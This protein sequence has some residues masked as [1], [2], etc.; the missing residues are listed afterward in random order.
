MPYLSLYMY[1]HYNTTQKSASQ[2]RV[3]GGH[4]IATLIVMID[5]GTGL[6]YWSRHVRFW[7]EN[8]P[9]TPWCAA[10][11]WRIFYLGRC[12]LLVHMLLPICFV[13]SSVP[14]VAVVWFRY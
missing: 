3:G 10:V 9:L 7:A 14:P 11:W 4:E 8:C 1:V 6:P 5:G 13:L 2:M 12:S